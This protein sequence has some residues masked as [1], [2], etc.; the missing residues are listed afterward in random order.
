MYL[1]SRAGCR[2]ALAGI[3]PRAGGGIA[4]LAGSTNTAAGRSGF[5]CCRYGT[6]AAA[7]VRAA[8]ARAPR[9]GT[10]QAGPLRPGRA[11]SRGGAIPRYFCSTTTPPPTSGGGGSGGGGGGSKWS[12][13]GF[14]LLGG[15]VLFT[16]GYF[17][18]RLLAGTGSSSSGRVSMD[19][20]L[21]RK[22]QSSVPNAHV[23]AHSW[24]C[25]RFLCSGIAEE[26]HALLCSRLYEGRMIAHG[27]EFLLACCPL[28]FSDREA[29]EDRRV[30]L[31]W[32]SVRRPPVVVV[33]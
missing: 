1:S 2:R 9:H 26:V 25:P 13:R 33:E 30:A 22:E 18:A 32:P 12:D 6:S 16:G 5:N 31:S 3:S 23:Y 7:A 28:L 15:A 17:G 11:S 10:G 20:S 8:A 24:V 19:R 27:R 4:A 29:P 14:A 21:A